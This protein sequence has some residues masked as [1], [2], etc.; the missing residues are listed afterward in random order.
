MRR[1]RLR[2][3]Q[4][5][6][7]SVL[8]AS[9]TR[10]DAK[11]YLQTYAS[12]N[13]KVRPVTS[14]KQDDHGIDQPIHVAIVKL[15]APQ[16]LDN[17]TLDGVA[18]TITQLRVLGLLSLVVVDCGLDESRDVFQDQAL[19]LCEAIESFG[20]PTAKLIDNVMIRTS[21]AASSTPSFLS[22]GV[23]VDDPGFLSQCLMHGMIPVIPSLAS[24]DELSLPKPSNSNQVV[25]ALTKYLTGYQFHQATASP[26]PEPTDGEASRPKKIASVQRV[27]ILDPLGGTPKT[28]RPGTC[29]RFINLEQEYGMLVKELMGPEGSP[30]TDAGQVQISAAT[31]ANNL[32]L[33]KEALAMLPA[34]S[35]T[36]ITTPFAAA[37]NMSP[38]SGALSAT[39][40]N[41][42][43]AFDGMVTTRKRQNPLLH[44]LLTDKPVYS[45][46]LPVQR[47][48]NGAIHGSIAGATT[49]IKRGMPVTIYPNP[50]TDPWTPPLPGSPRLRL[51]D[52]C[53]DLPRLIH[54]IEDSF[55]RKLDVEHYLNRVNENLAGIIIAGE[56]EG[57]AILTWEKP[58]AKNDQEPEGLVPYLDKFAVLKSQQGSG[59]VA[60]IVFNAMVRD[61]FPDGVCWRSRK[62][63][64][65][66]KWYFERSLGTKKLSESNWTMFWTTPG[67]DSQ[68]PTLLDYED[69]CRSVE[70]S[71][72]DNK[73]ILD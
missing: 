59:G 67:L 73:H 36:L 18:R 71:W 24:Q 41:R 43:F 30:V 15:R 7:V 39:S 70:P 42:G 58:S 44:N 61:C 35:S 57:G 12:E 68:H 60:D 3:Q 51:T 19:R 5:V 62:N 1:L 48:Q 37:N 21:E 23:R 56:Y 38:S 8:E 54:L 53:V 40:G 63:N 45:S 66:N 65:V 14:A 13:G 25:L 10:R 69:V 50:R 6:L 29:H 16:H 72:A 34:S 28:G 22:Q 33:A 31:H 55:N 17:E 27:I 64:P 46:S 32:S 2:P 26:A 49:L 11:G 20:R 4:D 9:A 47:I 52:K